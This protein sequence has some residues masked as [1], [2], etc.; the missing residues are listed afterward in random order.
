MTSTRRIDRRQAK[1]ARLTL[2]HSFLFRIPP[3][4]AWVAIVALL[5]AVSLVESLAPRDLWFGPAYLAVIAL[6]AWSISSRVAIAIGLL[7]LSAKLVM[8]TVPFYSPESQLRS[9]EH[10]SELKSLMR[11]SYAVLC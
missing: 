7:I 3:R 2:E 8:G 5:G 1:H 6:A 4:L 10:T 9:E 11:I